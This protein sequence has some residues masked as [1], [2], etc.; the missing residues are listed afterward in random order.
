MYKKASYAEHWSLAD[1]TILHTSK[2]QR[3]LVR[4][5]LLH[6]RAV[7]VDVNRS[8]AIGN[9]SD[10]AIKANKYLHQVGLFIGCETPPTPTPNRFD[11]ASQMYLW[12]IAVMPNANHL[13]EQTFTHMKKAASDLTDSDLCLPRKVCRRA[14]LF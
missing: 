3:R 13:I 14:R 11:D 7:T 12:Y 6:Q 1:S 8:C 10:V 2:Q 4:Y 5:L 9:I